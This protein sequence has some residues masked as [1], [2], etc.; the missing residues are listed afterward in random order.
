MGYD[1]EGQ[2]FIPAEEFWT[3]V[4]KYLPNDLGGEILFGPP[5]ITMDGYDLVIQYAL[6]TIC[7]PVDWTKKSRAEEQWNNYKLDRTIHALI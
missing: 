1:A 7:N 2:I 3:F 6:S 5:V 4:S